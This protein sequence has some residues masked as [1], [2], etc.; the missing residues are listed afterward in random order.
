MS[1]ILP[2]L[3]VKL[4]CEQ[5]T[6]NAD[7][8]IC[9]SLTKSLLIPPRRVAKKRIW[10]MRRK[11]L[12]ANWKMNLN[13]TKIEDF[14]AR[15]K[16]LATSDW[17]RTEIVVFPPAPY[18]LLLKNRFEGTNYTLGAQCTS[19]HVSGAYTGELSPAMA[20]DCGCK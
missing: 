20:A 5:R 11:I 18:L 12:A 10:N 14:V 9:D 15:L 2:R 7:S 19:E 8:D 17:A 3:L 1:Q 4:A 6:P 16:S 13:T